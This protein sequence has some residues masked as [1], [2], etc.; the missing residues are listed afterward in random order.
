MAQSP[1]GRLRCVP[2]LGM[3]EPWIVDTATNQARGVLTEAR[4]YWDV[5]APHA[6]KRGLAVSA[7]GRPL[8]VA[9]EV[10]QVPYR[11]LI[12]QVVT[13]YYVLRQQFW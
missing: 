9:T 1:G 8:Y 5:D 12:A 11:I 10:G 3:P 13:T 2:R 7:D 6:T 4:P